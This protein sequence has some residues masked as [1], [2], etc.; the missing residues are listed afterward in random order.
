MYERGIRF[1]LM[2]QYIKENSLSCLDLNASE[3]D[4]LG[5]ND[6]V[7]AYVILFIGYVL[8]LTFLVFEKLC[9]TTLPSSRMEQY[10]GALITYSTS[11]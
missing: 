11:E 10:H 1:R 5:F 6:V 4:P 7:T 3:K 2:Q 8:S 9:V